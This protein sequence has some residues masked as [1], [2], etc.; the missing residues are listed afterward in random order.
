M[1]ARKTRYKYTKEKKIEM[2]FDLWW[3]IVRNNFGIVVVTISKIPILHKPVLM[4][5]LPLEL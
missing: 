1:N 4:K 2:E 5:H 3:I